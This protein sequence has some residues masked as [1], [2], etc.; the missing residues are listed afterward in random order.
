MLAIAEEELGWV[1]VGQRGRPDQTLGALGGEAAESRPGLFI[2]ANLTDRF[3]QNG[4]LVPV[5]EDV[6]RYLINRNIINVVAYSE[7]TSRSID[8]E[9]RNG[10]W[11]LSMQKELERY[12]R[13]ARS[14]SFGNPATD[15]PGTLFDPDL[16]FLERRNERPIDR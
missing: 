4:F 12:K 7:N 3:A 5:E 2:S 6:F 15:S 13:S 8:Y 11:S 16:L 9:L 14:N 1:V 10:G